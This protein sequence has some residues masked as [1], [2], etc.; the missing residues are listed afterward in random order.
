MWDIFYVTIVTQNKMNLGL[1]NYQILKLRMLCPKERNNIH[2]LKK[3]GQ[4]SVPWIETG[5]EL[6]QRHESWLLTKLKIKI[7]LQKESSKFISTCALYLHYIVIK[8]K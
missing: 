4:V 1:I 7:N 6:V 3:N 8:R 2:I 5:S